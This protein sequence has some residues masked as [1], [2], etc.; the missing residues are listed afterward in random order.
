[1]RR[2]VAFCVLD[3]PQ[4]HELGWAHGR[5]ADPVHRDDGLVLLDGSKPGRLQRVGRDQRPYRP[6]GAGGMIVV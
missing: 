1:V 4:H 6:T 5:H 2:E 3:D